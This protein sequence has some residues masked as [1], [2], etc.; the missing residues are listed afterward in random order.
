MNRPDPLEPHK[1]VSEMTA[2]E[3][4]EYALSLRRQVRAELRELQRPQ[5]EKL[6]RQGRAKPRNQREWA[7]FAADLKG[8]QDGTEGAEPP[9]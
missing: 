6:L 9:A 7:I 5:R 2:G 8:K 4:R 1:P 3:R